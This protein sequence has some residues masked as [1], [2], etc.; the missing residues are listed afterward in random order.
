MR[1]FLF[2]FLSKSHSMNLVDIY[3]HYKKYLL[4]C[5]NYF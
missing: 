3:L 4:S 2:K 5:S 1:G